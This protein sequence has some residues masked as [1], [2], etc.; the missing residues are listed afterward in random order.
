MTKLAFAISVV[1]TG[2]ILWASSASAE[3]KKGQPETATTPLS[4]EQIEANYTQTIEKRVSDILAVLDLKDQAKAARIHDALI[5][6]YRALRRWQ[7]AEEA[8]SKSP[9]RQETNGE[10]QR[11]I[12]LAADRKAMHDRFIARLSADLTPEQL[13]KVKDKMTY[14]KTKVTYDAYCEILPSLTERQK[15]RIME[16]LKEAREQAMD[17]TSAEQKSAIFKKYK[18]K[19]NNYLSAEGYDVGRAYK[20]WGAKLKEKSAARPAQPP[21]KP[22]E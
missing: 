14:N 6:Q 16:M 8:K 10:N 15:G 9:P 11:D 21:A 2:V 17:G 19:I 3:T 20:D 5:D 18:G 7:D 4:A 13:E 12:Q 22:P 1:V